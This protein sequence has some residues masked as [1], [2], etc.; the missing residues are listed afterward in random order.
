MDLNGLPEESIRLHLSSAHN[1]GNAMIQLRSGLLVFACAIS[2]LCLLSDSGNA[3]ERQFSKPIV[4]GGDQGLATPLNDALTH[5]SDRALT[6]NFRRHEP[7]QL[8]LL[9][10]WVVESHRVSLFHGGSEIS[11][12]LYISLA[13]FPKKGW[14]QRRGNAFADWVRLMFT[15]MASC[16]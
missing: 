14:L 1:R 2:L 12:S 8:L 11:R 4:I 16:L 6:E 5:S 15:S 13:E 3:Q 9:A 7:E 10:I